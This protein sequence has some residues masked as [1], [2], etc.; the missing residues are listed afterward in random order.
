MQHNTAIHNTEL[1][2]SVCVCV[3]IS[4]QLV[5]MMEVTSIIFSN[6]D[7]V[8]EGVE[9]YQLQYKFKVTASLTKIHALLYFKLEG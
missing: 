8:T 3:Y 5:H 7:P 1:E 6:A 4:Q 9:K 2:N